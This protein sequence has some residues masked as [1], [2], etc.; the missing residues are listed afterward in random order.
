[1]EFSTHTKKALYKSGW[2]EAY[3]FNTKEFLNILKSNKYI[4]SPAAKVFL[5]KFGNLKVECNH[6]D[7]VGGV[8][9]LSTQIHPSIANRVFPN[10]KKFREVLGL[11]LCY[12]GDCR[13]GDVDL[14]I[15]ME[16][17]FYGSDDY[18]LYIIGN[19][20]VEALENIIHGKAEYDILFENEE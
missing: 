19:N 7:V 13:D 6:T 8:D 16:G 3:S 12:V 9:E 15:D 20:T 17:K 2:S 14:Y 5:H 11:E 10:I 18:G 4:V 1:M